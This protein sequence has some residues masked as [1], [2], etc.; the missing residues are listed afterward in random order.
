MK[1]IPK[2]VPLHEDPPKQIV[3]KDG[4]LLAV[5]GTKPD[6]SALPDGEYNLVTRKTLKGL[7]FGSLRLNC[8]GA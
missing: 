4:K 2:K 8:W 1:I 5:D 3:I 7:R 6:F